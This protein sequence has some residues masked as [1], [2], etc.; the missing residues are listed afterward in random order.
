MPVDGNA[1]T[2][3][4]SAAVTIASMALPPAASIAWPASAPSGWPIT[5]AF[6]ASTARVIAGS[7]AKAIDARNCRRSHGMW[8]HSTNRFH[9]ELH[10]KLALRVLP[11]RQVHAAISVAFEFILPD[12]CAGDG[13]ARRIR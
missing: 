5:S 1:T 3:A 13:I 2:P 7:A 6:G 9:G 8:F 12:C 10:L 4:T 11:G